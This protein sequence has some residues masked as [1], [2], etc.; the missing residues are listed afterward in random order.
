MEKSKFGAIADNVVRMVGNALSKKYNL[1][2]NTGWEDRLY[3]SYETERLHIR[4]TMGLDK[5]LGEHRI[6]R[7]KIASALAFSI[8]DTKPLIALGLNPSPG[9]RMANETLAIHC[10]SM[11]VMHFVE[12]RLSEIRPDER[13]KLRG[14]TFS[15][16]QAHEGPYILHLAKALRQAQQH[17]FDVYLVANIF[18]VL[19]SL[20]LR[21]CGVTV[22]TLTPSA[23]EL[24]ENG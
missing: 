23:T 10:S 17:Y 3:S 9:A 5:S 15:Y 24:G 22:P 11:I 14:K 19:E 8:L 16:P 20:F 4:K 2:W 7:H 6:D 18:F 1:A 21:G 12:Q 13:E